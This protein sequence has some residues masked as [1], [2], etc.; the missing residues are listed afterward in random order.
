M[1]VGTSA[2]IVDLTVEIV[3]QD[4]IHPDGYPA[5]RDGVF[6]GITTA[7]YELQNEALPAWHAARC[8]CAV[9]RCGHHN[10]AATRAEMLQAAAVLMRAIRSIDRRATVEADADDVPA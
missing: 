6:L 9:P 4:G 1:D 2:A 10:W 5:T 3:R 7:V 8:K